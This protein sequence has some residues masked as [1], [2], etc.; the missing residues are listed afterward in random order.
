VNECILG[1]Y[2]SVSWIPPLKS[3]FEN[4]RGSRCAI[5][6]KWTCNFLVDISWD[7]WKFTT[8]LKSWTNFFQ[9][10]I[11][12]RKISHGRNRFAICFFWKSTFPINDL[13]VIQPWYLINLFSCG[14]LVE[15][16]FVVPTTKY[17]K[18]LSRANAI[19]YLRHDLG[20][21]CSLINESVQIRVGGS[22]CASFMHF[23]DIEKL[24]ALSQ[25]DNLYWYKTVWV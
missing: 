11:H 13:R 20:D 24:L 19:H 10:Q 7:P 3:L 16:H 12:T 25:N 17:F 4:I 8:P 23:E 18:D 14:F 5:I 15:L 6:V 2:S 21:D 1:R 9:A 22:V